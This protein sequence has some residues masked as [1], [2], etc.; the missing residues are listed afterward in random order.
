MG[1]A[2]SWVK[3]MTHSMTLK[4]LT[5]MAAPKALFLVGA[6]IIYSCLQLPQGF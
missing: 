4:E 3:L 2:L 6:A 5:D 1:E